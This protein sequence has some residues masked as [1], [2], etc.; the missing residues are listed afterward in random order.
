MTREAP[1]RWSER[2]AA[3][4]CTVNRICRRCV[5]NSHTSSPQVYRLQGSPLTLTGF[6]RFDPRAKS[7]SDLRP[8]GRTERRALWLPAASMHAP[9]KRAHPRLR[10]TSV[11]SRLHAC[12]PHA[13]GL[14]G[15]LHVPGMA[16]CAGVPPFERAVARTCTWAVR[17]FHRCLCPA[18][19]LGTAV[20]E[21]FGARCWFGPPASRCHAAKTIAA[22]PSPER[23]GAMILVL[24]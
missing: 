24:R 11:H 12:A 23:D 1:A 19:R 21:A 4:A 2:F 20:P 5:L 14:C 13:V 8:K 6:F 22:R 9:K 15:L 18:R 3:S 17:P 16:T 7:L 10:S